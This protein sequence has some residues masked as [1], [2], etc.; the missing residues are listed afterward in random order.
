M[1]KDGPPQGFGTAGVVLMMSGATAGLRRLAP[2]S[3]G[4]RRLR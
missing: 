3:P 2:W 4:D 1:N